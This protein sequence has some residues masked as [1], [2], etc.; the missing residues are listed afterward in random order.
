MLIVMYYLCDKRKFY[1]QGV[2][3]TS[4]R[5]WVIQN[6]FLLDRFPVIEV[7]V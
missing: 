1:K 4:V 3:V 6:Q 5:P 2:S 7:I